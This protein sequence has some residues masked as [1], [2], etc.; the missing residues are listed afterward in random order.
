LKN[1]HAYAKQAQQA[2][3]EAQA[4]QA[5][6]QAEA[7]NASTAGLAA[8]RSGGNS[9][10]ALQETHKGYQANLRDI[11][12]DPNLSPQQRIAAV[13]ET[14]TALTQNWNQ[15][16]QEQGRRTAA[17]IDLAA[18]RQIAAAPGNPI[19]AARAT[20]TAAEGRL[21]DMKA[22]ARAYDIADI[23]GMQQQ[24]V[25]DQAS[26]RQTVADQAVQLTNLS[27]QLTAARDY[28]DTLAGATAIAAAAHRA[29]GE[30]RGPVARQTA[31]LA[32]Q[33][34]DNAVLDARRQRIQEQGAL[35]QAQHPNDTVAQAQ[36][37][38]ELA[39][40]EVASARGYDQ[41][42]QAQTDL[43]NA[44]NQY[45]DA[46]YN[47][48]QAEGQLAASEHPGDTVAQAAAIRSA[49]ARALGAARGPDQTLA[50][51]T[52]YNQANE[53]VHQAI[54]AR[55][56]AQ[57][58]LAAAQR[59]GDTVA[60]AAAIRSAA[61]RALAAAHGVDQTIAA[62]TAYSQANEQLHQA[63]VGRIQAQGQLAASEHPGDSVAQAQAVRSAAA[64]MLAAAH[65]IDQMIAAQTAYK[66]SNDQLNQA[67]VNRDLSIGDLA[68]STTPEPL[69]Q[70][71]DKIAA[72][73]K[74]LA[75]SVGVDARRTQRT[76]LN[77]LLLQRATTAADQRA[78]T[79]DFEFQMMQIT[80]GQAAAMLTQLAHNKNLS[81]AQR[82]QYLEQ[83]RRYQLGLESPIGGTGFDLAPGNP[84]LP[85]FYDVS[86]AITGGGSGPTHN[87]TVDASATMS[88][89][90][91]VGRNADVGLVADAIDRTTGAGLSQRLRAAGV[92]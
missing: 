7:Q 63:I 11:A 28:G 65:G 33:Q 81:Q 82:D 83:A 86:R 58:Q 2:S 68:A 49:A 44:N 70:L 5:L 80:A 4:A 51:R 14:N 3:D 64:R 76:N 16:V 38:R 46:I 39:Q 35:A 84:R 74:A 53:Q 23:V 37:L 42:V 26:F 87:N 57:G 30:A 56:Q 72:A 18:A 43:T 34:A 54:V 91:N 85:T 59:P 22:H 67:I 1:A 60:Q 90:V 40:K 17:N 20:L 47:R 89:V 12:R 92:R 25:Q 41:Q 36:A 6:Q 15:Q 77:S 79:V 48:I 9:L 78:S 66:Q 55:I 32:A 45:N 10:A 21:A 19:V 29:V 88:I 27:G 62:Q 13:N 73:R 61:A 71:D 50:A 52:S 31:T 75:D 24:V 8:A 69:K